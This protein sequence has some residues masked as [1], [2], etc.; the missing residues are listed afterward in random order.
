MKHYIPI[1]YCYV[2]MV[3]PYDNRKTMFKRYVQGYLKKSYPE[4]TLVKIEGMTAIC[5][6]RAPDAR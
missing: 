5:E 1:P 3:K 4:M 2:W 6:R